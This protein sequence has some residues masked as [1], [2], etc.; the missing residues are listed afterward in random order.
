M[1]SVYAQQPVSY[2]TYTPPVT[3][4]SFFVASVSH[5]NNEVGEPVSDSSGALP[6]VSVSLKAN[7]VS[8]QR[9]I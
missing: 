7:P 4:P 8:E 1:H 3:A 6:G 5:V 9:P 2:A